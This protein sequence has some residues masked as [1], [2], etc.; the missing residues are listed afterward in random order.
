MVDKTNIE[1][2][3]ETYL[4]G[5]EQYLVSVKVEAGNRIVVEVDSDQSISID[6]C[7]TLSRFIE[8]RLDREVEDYEL[9]VGSAGITSPFQLLRQYQKNIGREVEV[10]SK[11]GKKLTG[12]LHS[13]DEEKMVLSVEKQVKPEGAKR[14]ITV[15]ENQEFLYSEIKYTKNVI[16]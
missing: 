14:K 15:V 9:E 12:I 11:A 6:D 8:S 2:I 13:A 4:T 10:L 7:A 16:K 1:E 5:S 3:V